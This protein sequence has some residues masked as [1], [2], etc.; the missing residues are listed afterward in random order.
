MADRPQRPTAARDGPQTVQGTS[1][2]PQRQRTAKGSPGPSERPSEAEPDRTCVEAT[3]NAAIC[4]ACGR[5][6]EPDDRGRSRGRWWCIARGCWQAAV[7]AHCDDIEMLSM[8]GYG[9]G[10]HSQIDALAADLTT[11]DEGLLDD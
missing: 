1:G 10:F 6:P 3:A 4:P 5:T 8:L 2:A 11:T 9:V 7:D